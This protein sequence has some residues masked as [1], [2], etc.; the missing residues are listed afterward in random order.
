M[1]IRV[2]KKTSAGRR[3]ASVNLL[4][5]VTKFTPQKSLLR[6]QKRS[7]GR[8][9]HGVITVHCRGGGAKRRYRVMDFSRNK[10][11]VVGKVV[12]IEYDPNRSSNIALIEYPDGDRRYIIAPIGL[13]D[14]ATV[15]SSTQASEP[16][17]GNAMPLKYIPAGLDVHNIELIAGQGGKLCRSAGTYARLTNK[18]GEWATL[19]FPS[20]EIRQ[21]A[22]DARA[23]IGQ[24]GNTDHQNVSLGKAGRARHL[25]R[26]PHIRGMATTHDKHPM[27]G[28]SGRSKGNRPPSSRTGVLSKGGKTRKPDKP[29]NKRII[30]RRYSKR[31]GQ[32]V[33]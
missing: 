7:S 18:E 23:T 19:V 4:S 2:Y 13:T 26:R 33:L 12:G 16:R 20:G 29:S 27:G 22:V 5:E 32:L 25:G 6:P 1:A 14:G 10:L 30:R 3:N 8:N 17:A 31:Y 28:G 15:V 21:I 11:D 24:V 9:H